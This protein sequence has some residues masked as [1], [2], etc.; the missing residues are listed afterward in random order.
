MA[1][2]IEVGESPGNSPRCIARAVDAIRQGLASVQSV[3]EEGRIVSVQI[4]RG[5]CING[6]SW[7]EPAVR[8]ASDAPTL[9]E[10]DF[11][12]LR[13]LTRKLD[14][15]GPPPEQ[16][17]SWRLD[18]TLSEAVADLKRELDRLDLP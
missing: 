14:A 3:A 8:T 12:R 15:C 9:T 4:G 17:S 18:R 10:L 16:E 2:A 11:R 6:G 1:L 13:A 7:R 5:I